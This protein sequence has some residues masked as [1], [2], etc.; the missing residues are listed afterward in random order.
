[1]THVPLWPFCSEH[2]MWWLSRK[3]H[4]LV[5]RNNHTDHVYVSF[6]FGCP[7]TCECLSTEWSDVSCVVVV[8]VAA[9]QKEQLAVHDITLYTETYARHDCVAT[10]CCCWFLSLKYLCHFFF[11]L[12]FI[13]VSLILD[14]MQLFI[15]IFHP[16]EEKS[17]KTQIHLENTNQKIR[18]FAE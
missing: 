16:R 7:Y 3:M 12:F 15:C 4:L 9:W 17:G 10:W 6:S 13:F 1:M 5:R 2:R 14:Q 8:V 11:S 18:S